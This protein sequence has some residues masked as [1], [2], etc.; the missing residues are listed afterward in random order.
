[1][2][3]L[4]RVDGRRLIKAL[5]EAGFEV[6]RIRGSHHFLR[7]ADGRA[8]VVPVHAGEHIGVGLVAQILRDCDMTRDQLA[9]LL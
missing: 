8:T 2:S 4:P 6:V 7:H 3:K 9:K 1:M 5:Q